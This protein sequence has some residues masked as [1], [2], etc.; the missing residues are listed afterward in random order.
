MHNDCMMDSGP[1]GADRGTFPENDIATW[2][3]YV[4]DNISGNSYGGEP[5][6]QSDDTGEP[7]GTPY[8]WSNTTDVCGPNGLIKYIEDNKI[9]YLNVSSDLITFGWFP[10]K[11]ARLISCHIAWQP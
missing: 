9:A 1:Q 2:R 3:K 5:C 7:D 11:Q 8:D 6:G 4:I 10:S